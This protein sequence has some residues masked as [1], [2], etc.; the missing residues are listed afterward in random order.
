MLCFGWRPRARVLVSVSCVLLTTDFLVH[1]LE[2]DVTLWFKRFEVCADA[3][4]WDN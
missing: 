2:D 1:G 4:K 3:N